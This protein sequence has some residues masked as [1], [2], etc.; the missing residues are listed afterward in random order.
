MRRRPEGDK[1][2]SIARFAYDGARPES[3][4]PKGGIEDL[5]WSNTGPVVHKWHHYLPIYQRYFE[6]FVDTPVRILEIG[7]SKGGSLQLW[8]RFF[9]PQA[10]IFG[11]DINPDCAQFD[12][13]AGQVRIG[14]QDDAGFLNSVVDE[15]GGLDIVL[16]DGSHVSRHIRA[17]L[18]ALYPRLGDGGVYMI[19]DLHAAYWPSFGGGYG[20][21]R[22]FMSDVKQIIDDMHHWYHLEGEKVRPTA[23]HVAG[24]HVYDS[25]VVLEKERV[26]APKHSQIGDGAVM[27]APSRGGEA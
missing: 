25:I 2:S 6:R 11:I 4:A 13:Q 19:E 5:F 14:S 24:L 1:I 27:S 21:S 3:D 22:S 10:V 9:G 15:M 12:G 17:S 26:M 18:E 20:K 8:R 7:V 16:D 23:G